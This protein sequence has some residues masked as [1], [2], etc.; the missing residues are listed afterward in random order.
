MEDDAPAEDW[1][2]Q[3]SLESVNVDAARKQAG[4]AEWRPLRSGAQL[5][6]FAD[7]LVCVVV[8]QVMKRGEQYLQTPDQTVFC[9]PFPML[10]SVASIEATGPTYD[11]TRT[12]IDISTVDG[13]AYRCACVSKWGAKRVLEGVKRSLATKTGAATRELACPSCGKHCWRHEGRFQACALWG[14]DHPEHEGPGKG[15]DT[16]FTN[17]TPL[18]GC[19]DCFGD[20]DYIVCEKCFQRF[21]SLVAA[22][23]PRNEDEDAPPQHGPAQKPQRGAA[24]TPPPPPVVAASARVAAKKTALPLLKDELATRVNVFGSADA[25][26][27]AVDDG[28]DGATSRT[29]AASMKVMGRDEGVDRLPEPKTTGQ[30]LENILTVHGPRRCIGWRDQSHPDSLCFTWC[31]Y[32]ELLNAAQSV[33]TRLQAFLRHQTGVQ[34]VGICGANCLEWYI[35]DF[36]CLISTAAS[37]STDGH[38]ETEREDVATR[39]VSVPLHYKLSADTVV[40]IIEQAQLRCVFVDEERRPMFHE[41]VANGTCP[42][43][44]IIPMESLDAQS[45]T[46]FADPPGPATTRAAEGTAPGPALD[47]AVTLLFTSGTSGTPKGAV[48]PDSSWLFMLRQTVEASNRVVP[49]DCVDSNL[50][51]TASRTNGLS[52]LAAGGCIGLCALGVQKWLNGDLR[53]L[54]P[55][56][57]VDVPAITNALYAQFQAEMRSE[58][59]RQQSRLPKHVQ[60][61][62]GVRTPSQ[63][64]F[65]TVRRRY[66]RLIGSSIE[67]I[68]IG[69]AKTDPQ[70]MAWMKLV[71]GDDIVTESYGISE[72]GGVADDGKVLDGVEVKLLPWGE[73]APDD[74]PYPRGELLV[75][76]KEV[77]TGA[78]FQ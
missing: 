57:I 30:M 44:L 35:A 55:T 3:T 24:L 10:S 47:N 40:S 23:P 51:L 53:A 37:A 45:Q 70:A 36:A 63:I 42:D 25:N 69:G 28:V 46:Q 64:A 68:V 49:V 76:T 66:R 9:F 16:I 61:D 29:S 20:C 22:P 21:S 73:F 19:T 33:R 1:P 26:G 54:Q 27:S 5:R 60:A 56:F 65:E 62:D 31:T 74:T 34:T 43:L 15:A 41:L 4:D 18:Y 58:V 7:G 38:V 67:K 8:G 11:G 32:S 48:V 17:H 6:L 78:H 14:C 59:V 75:R 39:L 2:E 71:F 52:A 12:T 77:V 72:V 50:A 13:N